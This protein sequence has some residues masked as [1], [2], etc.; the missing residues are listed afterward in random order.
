MRMKKL[1]LDAVIKNIEQVTELVNQ[2]LEEMD[3]PLK[4]QL[5]VDVAVDEMFTNIASYAYPDGVGQASVQVE[6]NVNPHGVRITFTDRGIPYN[7]LLKED[8]DVTLSAAERKIGGLG[9]FLV[10]KTM[11]EMLYDYRDGCNVLT[12]VKYF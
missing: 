6:P 3:C 10:K 9:I 2:Q 4:A 7:P 12:I 8:P 1:V 11:D 5:Q